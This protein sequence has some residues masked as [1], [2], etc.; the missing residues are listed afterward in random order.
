M[1]MRNYNI[2]ILLLSAVLLCSCEERHPAPFEDISGVYFNNLSPTMMVTDSL[3]LTFVYESADSVEVPVRVQ[4]MGRAT[5]QPR[6]LD[7]TVDSDDAVLGVDYLLPEAAVMPAD[8]SHVDYIV[9]LIRTQALKS[10]KKTIGLR[11]HANEYFTLPVSHVVQ[12]SDTVSTLD[13]TISFS[14]MFTKA[15]A[16][17]E[18][19]LIG[20]FT[21]QKFELACDVLNLDPADFNDPSVMTLAKMLYIST[22]MSAYVEA[23]VQK[24]EKG[25][26]YDHNAFD[27][28]TGEPLSYRKS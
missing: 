3:D 4:L 5:G 6:P 27:L 12:V 1:I 14:D 23:E 19:N 7:I 13:F 17:W 25:L 9:T 24:K 20:E 16:A 15:P 28:N 21:Q 2:Y 8:T 11:I 22:E 18:A 26:E 10:S